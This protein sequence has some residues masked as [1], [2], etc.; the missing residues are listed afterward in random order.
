MNMLKLVENHSSFSP[1]LPSRKETL[2]RRVYAFITDLYAIVFFN[3]FLAFCWTSAVNTYISNL[4]LG[5]Y[6]ASK[7]LF[8]GVETIS[9][10]IVIVSYFFF[11][12][13]LNEGKTF[14]K[15]LFRL[16]VYSNTKNQELTV[17]EALSRSITYILY[18]YFFYLPFIINFIRKDMKSVTD[19]VSQTTVMTDEEFA[20]LE[21]L[22]EKS[23]QDSQ[24]DMFPEDPVSHRIS[25]AS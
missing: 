8:N 20:V 11:S 21:S 9:L 24:L 22:E 6:S 23:I 4:A 25:Q 17:M 10:P 14:G 13:F 2:K 16:K 1:S 19:Y 12:Y 18:S 15:M 7:T 3:K 5:K